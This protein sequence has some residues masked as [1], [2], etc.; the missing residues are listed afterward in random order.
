MRVNELM[1]N[2]HLCEEP[3]RDYL[4]RLVSKEGIKL[5]GKGA[6]SHVFQHPQ[7][8]NVVVK[9]YTA[10]DVLFKDYVQWCLK[11]QHNIYVPQIIEDIPYSDGT[12]NYHILFMQKMK[13]I[14]DAQFEQILTKIMKLDQEADED[15][16][17][18]L[19]DAIDMVDME[20]L[21]SFMRTC[22][23]RGYG[24]KHLYEIW[25]KIKSYGINKIDLH[26]ANVMLRGNQLVF[27]D[28]VASEPTSRL[29]LLYDDDVEDESP[30]LQKP[31][32]GG[33]FGSKRK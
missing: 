30:A 17:Y 12:N 18:L 33:I 8:H 11:N 16:V 25:E 9:V 6:Y 3:L 32:V 7:F 19:N 23:K 20:G 26:S 22:F 4:T 21:N 15:L 1:G 31:R 29:D 28:P 27:T 14:N 13:P 10:K 24:D 2:R 5:I